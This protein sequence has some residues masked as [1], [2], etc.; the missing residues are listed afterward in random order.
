MGLIRLA[1]LA[2]LALAGPGAHGT[3]HLWR[4]TELYS[5]AD[6]SV[7]FLELLVFEDGEEFLT[8]HGLFTMTLAGTTRS[9]L[10]PGDVG[11]PT[12]GK[13]LLVGTAGFAALGVVAPD[14]VVPNGFFP[15]AGGT[16][17]FANVD[18]WDVPSLP[19]T[20]GISLARDGTR[21]INS[22]RNFAGR[23]GTVAEAAEVNVQALWWG[24]PAGSESGWGLNITHQGEILFATWFTYDLDGSGMWLVAPEARRTTGNTYAGP[25]YRTTGPAFSTTPFDPARIASSQV[26][27]I[28]LSFSGASAGTF[29]YTVNGVSQSKSITRQVFGTTVPT[30]AAGGAPGVVNY[31]DLW[32]RSSESGWGVNVTHQG[33]VLFATWFTYDATGRG[34]WLVMPEARLSSPG[35][36]AGRLYRT[37]GPAF[38]AV[39]FDSAAIG[40]SDVGQGSFTFSDSTA[41]TFAYTVNGIAQSKGI[42]RQVYSAPATVCR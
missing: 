34:M 6:G 8:N 37:T 19:T 11:A 5:N 10:F 15:I 18:T 28:T 20:G 27:S 39:P 25:L 31:Q 13:H 35:V 30:C 38:N 17:N 7:Q 26:G 36:Y 1:L 42:T 23:T 40:I 24:A 33:D 4:M 9:Y 12:A 14:Y 21:A 3:H 29:A 2:I 32:W 22:P 41:G 16:L